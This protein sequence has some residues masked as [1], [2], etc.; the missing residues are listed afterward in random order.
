[1]VLL[2]FEPAI[3]R[4]QVSQLITWSCLLT[5]LTL[6]SHVRVKILK[7]GWRQAAPVLAFQIAKATEFGVTSYSEHCTVS[8]SAS[9]TVNV[10]RERCDCSFSPKLITELC[11]SMVGGVF[12]AKGVVWKRWRTNISLTYL[13]SKFGSF[14]HSRKIVF[15]KTL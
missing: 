9:Y 7:H 6:I 3:Y 2:G 13:E 14:P 12:V 8:F 5:V 11:G 10:Y 1:M 15:S 4:M